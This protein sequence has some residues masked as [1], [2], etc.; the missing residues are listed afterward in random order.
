[1]EHDAA[2]KREGLL[3]DPS[4]GRL[5]RESCRVPIGQLIP[6]GVDDMTPFV[7]CC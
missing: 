6:K 2:V 3:T 7:Q 5:S 4:S 1:M